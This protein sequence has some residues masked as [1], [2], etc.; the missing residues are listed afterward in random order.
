MSRIED[1]QCKGAGVEKSLADSRNWWQKQSEWKTQGQKRGSE[2]VSAGDFI[3][4][5]MRSHR[6]LLGRGDMIQ[7]KITL[8][9]TWRLERSKS[10]GRN[11]YRR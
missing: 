2:A 1:S 3:L 4:S 7:L 8:A 11:C 9:A 5:L 10:E 6:R